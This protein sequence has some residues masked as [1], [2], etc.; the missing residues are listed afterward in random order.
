MSAGERTATWSP[1]VKQAPGAATDCCWTPETPK[2]LA[3]LG[4]A[5]SRRMWSRPKL[6][7]PPVSSEFDRLM[8]SSETAAHANVDGLFILK[9]WGGGKY[10]GLY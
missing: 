9:D 5:A 6:P 4:S 1:G 8:S 10:S 7:S 3:G 2:P